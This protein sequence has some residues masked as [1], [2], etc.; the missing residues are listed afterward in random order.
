MSY[1][2]PGGFPCGQRPAQPPTPFKT[3]K[4]W[5]YCHTHG[6]DVD[7]NHTGMSCRNPGPAHNP[8]ATRTNTME[9]S[10]TGLHRTILP[11]ISGRIQPRQQ[12]APAPT[13]WQ[14]PLPPMN[15]TPMMAAMHPMMPPTP[16]QVINYMGQQ[17]GHSPPQFGLTPPAVAPPAPP[18]APPAGM[19]MPYYNPY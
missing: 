2:Q 5:N 6:G 11:S 13:M 4:N 18:P 19:M 8:N 16:Y 14:Q 9:G 1:Q 15:F 12:R 7:N 17:F 10:I 3:F